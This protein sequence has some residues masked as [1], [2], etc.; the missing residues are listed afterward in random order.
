MPRFNDSEPLKQ[1]VP[2]GDYILCVVDFEIGISTGKKTSGSEKYDV[3][4]EVEG[5]GSKVYEF[6]I[7]HESMA[8]RTDCFLKSGGVRDLKKGQDFTFRADEAKPGVP[9]ID[10]RGLRCP[11]KL[12]VEEYTPTNSTEKR[13]KN[14]VAVWYTDRAPLP[15]NE[16]LRVDEEDDKPF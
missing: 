12:V 9:W 14:K 2:E 15:P 10:P 11:V 6:L 16:S 7:D 1:F 5:Q 4:F 3:I 8:W 13:K